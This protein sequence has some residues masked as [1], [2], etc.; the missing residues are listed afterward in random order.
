M[1]SAY[2]SRLRFDLVQP[3]E[4]DDIWGV[5][6]NTNLG[7][8]VEEAIAGVA[9]VSMTD[10]DYTLTTA[11]GLADEARKAVLQ[12]GSSVSLTATRNIIVPSVTKVYL[13]INNTT[14]GQSITVKTAT[15]TGVTVTNG[16]KAI[17]YC[18]A[19]NVIEAITSVSTSTSSVATLVALKALPTPASNTVVSVACKTT[20][21]D[22]FSGQFEWRSTSTA[23]ADDALVVQ[24][25]ATATGRFHRV[26]RN[27]SYDVMWWGVVLNAPGSAASNATAI[28]AAIQAVA[29]PGGGWLMFPAG[30]IYVSATLDNN[31]KDVL[32]IGAGRDQ[33]HNGGTNVGATRIIATTAIT[34]LKHR[35]PINPSASKNTGGGWI[36]MHVVAN[37]IAT[38][39]LHCTSVNLYNHDLYLEDCVGTEAALYDCLVDTV[40]LAD[41]AT[42]QKGRSKLSIRQLNTGA[43]YSCHGVVLGNQNGVANVSL[44]DFDLDIL[45]ANG[46]A[47]KVVN[48][49]NVD[50]YLRAHGVGTGFG[51]YSHGKTGALISA[52]TKANP[53]VVTTTSAHGFSTGQVLYIDSVAGMTQL[54]GFYKIVSLTSTTFSLQ[55]L[56][57]VNVNSTGYS[58]YTSGGV[59][60]SN[61][62]GGGWNRYRYVSSVTAIYQE[63]TN[64]SGV[65]GSSPNFIHYDSSNGT[66]KPTAGTGAFWISKDS[67]GN[68][69][70]GRHI[71]PVLAD[72]DT[73]TAIGFAAKLGNE[74]VRMWSGSE[75]QIVV[76]G[77]AG[78]WLLRSL[79]AGNNFQIFPL[80]GGGLCD[81]AGLSSTALRA[82]ASYADD[83]AAAAAGISLG[84]F[85]RNGSAVQC[86]I[87]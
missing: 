10:A 4:F 36:N 12:V 40:E 64:I 32:C 75:S 38:R 63:G 20:E 6:T 16:N 72:G 33:F 21:G 28:N 51:V 24:I 69:A 60:Y 39:L 58:T 30:A 31:V 76:G 7:T 87:T 27:F 68:I 48:A 78:T 34:V 50:V 13:V 52:A 62:Q 47:L 41:S 71:T 54:L 35:S 67:L 45:H 9:A 70:N 82:S 56:G 85:Y 79:T 65:I 80:A 49:D 81:I 23:T 42:I 1:P 2:S 84:Q 59:A 29:A 83:A 61:P 22:G 15:G 53:C 86:R 3:G 73:A 57:G 44:T 11:N 8:L 5:A 74:C 19:T 46:H 25:S 55:T 37:G 43:A 66:P 17:V 18:D 14:G 26:I 77:P